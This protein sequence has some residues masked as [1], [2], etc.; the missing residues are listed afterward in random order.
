M[1]IAATSVLSYD[2][3]TAIGLTIKMIILGWAS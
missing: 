3:C 2:V 1:H